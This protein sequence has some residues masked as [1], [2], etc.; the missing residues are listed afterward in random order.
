MSTE[1]TTDPNDVV[2]MAQMAN[3]ANETLNKASAAVPQETKDLLRNAKNR[4]LDNDK[5]RSFSSFV[6]KGEQ[7]AFSLTVQPGILCP[8]LKKNI[9]YFYLNYILIAAIVMVIT[10]LATMLNP[11]TIII[12]AVLLLAWFFVLQS[13]ADGGMKLG[14]STVSRKNATSVMMVITAIVLFFVV[15]GVFFVTLTSA[16]VIALIHAL[17]RDSSNI[18]FDESAD[19][20][21]VTSDPADQVA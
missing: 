19:G 14:S 9:L 12:V 20:G 4:V 10:L 15:K 17:L 2:Q 16:S 21:D 13:T 3:T 6:G 5:L 8:R 7:S 11:K 18:S 1:N